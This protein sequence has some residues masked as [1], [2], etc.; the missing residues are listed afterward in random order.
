MSAA[1]VGNTSRHKPNSIENFILYMKKKVTRHDPKFAKHENIF[2]SRTDSVWQTL[3]H[4]S[5][6]PRQASRSRPAATTSTRPAVT[7]IMV[8]VMI[9]IILVPA[10]ALGP[11]KHRDRDLDADL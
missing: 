8:M 9:R 10:Q 1:L 2:V 11:E 6:K 3:Q 7:V 5:L 4:V